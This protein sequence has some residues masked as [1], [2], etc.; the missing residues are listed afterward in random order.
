MASNL[1]DY[2]YD[3]SEDY[4]VEGYLTPEDSWH[5]TIPTGSGAGASAPFALVLAQG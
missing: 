4:D 1:D 5:S 2:D 3:A